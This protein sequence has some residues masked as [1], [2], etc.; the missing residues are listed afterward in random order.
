MITQ[1]YYLR[2]I[3]SA[4][5]VTVHFL[6]WHKRFDIVLPW[7]SARIR[8]DKKEPLR[9]V[10][11]PIST[12]PRPIAAAPAERMSEE[13]APGAAAA[14]A[15]K[16]ATEKKAGVPKHARAVECLDLEG[17]LLHTYSSG[18]MAREALGVSTEDI[19]RCCRGRKASAGGFVFRFMDRARA[20]A[21]SAAVKAAAVCVSST[22]TLQ[23]VEEA[24]EEAV[25]E[26]LA[27]MSISPK[28]V[29]TCHSDI[30]SSSTYVQ[31][32]LRSHEAG[33]DA[34]LSSPFPCLDEPSLETRIA[35]PPSGVGSR[36]AHNLRTAFD[37]EAFPEPRPAAALAI[38]A[39]EPAPAAISRTP[40]VFGRSRSY[41]AEALL[42]P[43]NLL[44][45]F[46]GEERHTRRTVATIPSSAAEPP[47]SQVLAMQ[48]S[49][50]PMQLAQA[51]CVCEA[52]LA[53]SALGGTASEGGLFLAG[54]KRHRDLEE[55]LFST[56]M[57]AS[58]FSAI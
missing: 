38:G 36:V 52:V 44:A 53:T 12:A 58:V 16:A 29:S 23:A 33:Q 1:T 14:T 31:S 32:P 28:L 42:R 6:G 51:T 15:V 55:D 2:T 5:E 8:L 40:R 19:S 37:A 39:P 17:A 3:T 22:D 34:P 30:D 41:H 20:A 9:A 11:R 27:S 48:P 4:G 21:A 46:N 54:T 25:V 24:V 45:D 43:Y 18:S 35:K 26:T 7:D 10:P 57:F 50:P 13:G 49:H 56:T 47:L